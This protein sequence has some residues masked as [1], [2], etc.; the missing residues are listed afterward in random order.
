MEGSMWNW[1]G[2]PKRD[3]QTKSEHPG[4]SGTLTNDPFRGQHPWLFRW[5]PLLY[6][7]FWFTETAGSHP[8]LSTWMWFALFYAVFLLAYFRAF[9][10]AQ[11]HP[12]FWLGVMFALGYVYFPF[13]RYAA[14]E[15]VYPVVMIVF[16]IRDRRLGT[17]LA[18][19]SAV[20]GASI[21]GVLIETKLL[22]SPPV[23]AE[24]VIFFMVAIGFSNFAFS[25]HLLMTQQLARANQEIEHL[26]Q[27]AERERI[28][29]DLHDLLGHT[30]TVIVL[31]SDVAN[32]LFET[33]PEMAHR[34]IAEVEETARKA[35]AD[36]REAV[37]GYRGEGVEAEVSRARRTLASAGVQ[38]TTNVEAVTI[39]PAQAD[40]L[41][42]VLREAVTNVIR[43]AGAT[44]CRL[45][46]HRDGNV[47][48]MTVEDNGNGH[49]G[50]EGNGL[51]GMRERVTAAGGAVQRTQIAGGGTRVAVELHS[52]AEGSR[53]VKTLDAEIGPV[54]GDASVVRA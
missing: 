40:A 41:C 43:H 7:L 47:L 33:E 31:K 44:A 4:G 52:G 6:T 11:R 21:V 19:F 29:R 36:V 13:N 46:L 23:V 8:P 15:F 3:A 27:I 39:T 54:S 1:L 20:Q 30:L 12:A 28:A 5:P 18:Q 16:L 48:R 10:R 53:I 14:G 38:L 17:A 49:L 2:W 50:S 34:E 45:E 37:A 35:L 32:R 42:L 9:A 24:N 25:R 51:R 26:A 22:H